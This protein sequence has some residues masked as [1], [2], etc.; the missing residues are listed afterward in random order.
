MR[1]RIAL[2]AMDGGLL[3][4][5]PQPFAADVRPYCRQHRPSP[6]AASRTR[7]DT[8]ATKIATT[9]T[10]FPFEREKRAVG[11]V[12]ECHGRPDHAIGPRLGRDEGRRARNLSIAVTTQRRR[13][14]CVGSSQRALQELPAR[15]VIST[16]RSAQAAACPR[17]GRAG[18]AETPRRSR[19][20]DPRLMLAR[21]NSKVVRRD[22]LAGTGRSGARSGYEA[23]HQAEPA[24]LLLPARRPPSRAG[25]SGARRRRCR[26]PPRRAGILAHERLLVAVV[27][28]RALSLPAREVPRARCARR[29]AGKGTQRSMYCTPY[30]WWRDSSRATY[31]SRSLSSSSTR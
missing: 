14:V 19:R 18:S 22:A 26:S 20:P 27:D 6:A 17:G 8:I 15:R 30:A 7:V 24:A 28:Q 23:L 21:R 1:R 11:G 13:C 10:S 25:T 5:R 4:L 2:Q 9:G 12:S 16:A 29:P 31:V 3:S